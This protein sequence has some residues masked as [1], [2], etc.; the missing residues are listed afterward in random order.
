MFWGYP[1]FRKHPAGQYKH[2]VNFQT[3]KNH[4]VHRLNDLFYPWWFDTFFI[5]SP[6]CEKWIHFDTYFATNLKPP[7]RKG[8]ANPNHQ[9]DGFSMAMLVHQSVVAF[10]FEFL[11]QIVIIAMK[12]ASMKHSPDGRYEGG[13]LLMPACSP[14][15]FGSCVWRQAIIPAI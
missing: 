2:T 5:F 3:C 14:W 1:Y 11:G 13:K 8:N 10:L 4:L 9:N 12:V 6:S 7:T 15:F